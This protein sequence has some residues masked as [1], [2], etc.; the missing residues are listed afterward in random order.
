MIPERKTVFD[1]FLKNPEKNICCEKKS[2]T[3]EA[4]VETFFINRLLADFGFHDNNIKT[5]ESIKPVQIAKGSKRI[6]YQPDYLIKVKGKVK[7]VIDAKSTAENIFDWTEQ[8]A[9]YC[10]VLNRNSKENNVDYFLLSNGLKTALFKWDEG[11]PIIEL[12]FQD[13]ATTNPKYNILRKAISFNALSQSKGTTQEPNHFKLKRIDKEDA[14]KL[15]LSCHKYIWKTEKMSPAPAFMEFIKIIFLKLWNDRVIKENIGVVDTDIYVPE[16][17]NTFSVKWL[18]EREKD[19]RNPLSDLKYKELLELIEDE[20]IKDNK[21]RMFDEEDKIKLKPTTI[22]GV[23]KKLENVY[24]FGIDEDLNGRLFESFLNATMRGAELGQYFTPRSIVLL[25]TKLAGLKASETHIDTVLD[26]SCGTGG[27]LIEV[28]T[29]MRKQIRENESYSTEKKKELIDKIAND[30]IFGIDAA[31]EPKLARIA[32]INMYLYGDGGSHIY[33]ADGLDN[34]LKVD[35]NEPVEIQLERTELSKRFKKIVDDNKGFDVVLTNPPFSMWYELTNEQEAKVLKQY[36]L[37]KAN[38][39]T[40]KLRNRLRGSAL[41]IERYYNL[42]KPTGKLISVIDD[43]ILAS[44]DYSFVRDFIRENFIIRAIISLHGDAFRRSGA[45]VKTS[46]LYLEKKT[47]SH[48]KQPNAF[49]YPSIRL[50]V[51]DLPMTTSKTK[52]EE[53]RKLAKKEIGDIIEKFCDFKEGKKTIWSVPPERL[54]DRLDFK[55]CIPMQGR[56]IKFWRGNGFDIAK[57]KDFAQLKDEII[58]PK[59]EPEKEFKILAIGYDGRCIIDEIRKGK[60]INYKK[61]RVVRDGDLVFSRYNAFH[62]AIGFI[63]DEFDGCLASGSYAV[64]RCKNSYDSLYLWSILRSAELRSEILS[65]S[66]GMGRQTV[67]WDNLKEIEFP[68]S[69]EAERKQIASNLLK[70]WAMEKEALAA[71]QNVK[72]ILNEKYKIDS[73]DSKTRF[74]FSKPPR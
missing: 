35:K 34:E 41:F 68:L 11:A 21:K 47:S 61:M 67:E 40:S 22:K 42:L 65:S 53:A 38:G 6:L 7:L 66:I 31:S 28:L 46:L 55:N 14:E 33:F 58:E 62:G 56:F 49:Y 69:K 29:E 72:D 57:V 36:S 9:H 48:D 45:R 32:R 63:T 71:I 44:K 10:L 17:L 16:E 24:L 15:F 27:F 8:C 12:D 64:V 18:E 23:V 37:I 20:I 50:G 1:T 30:S 3:N 54:K 73:D 5:K 19:T 51:D 2:L 25:A 43:T 4:S 74:E 26:G 52:I 60:D 13:F 70:A 39:A 59:N